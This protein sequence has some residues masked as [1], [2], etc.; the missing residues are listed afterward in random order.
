MCGI[1]GV[2]ANPA[3]TIKS[4]VLEKVVRDV[5]NLSEVRG[6]D[7]SGALAVFPERIELIKSS[8]RVSH[9]VKQPQFAQ[10]LNNA[11]HAYESAN[12]FAVAGHTRMATNGS[13]GKSF[14]NQPVIKDD[15]L[16]LHNGIIVNDAELWELNPALRKEYEVDTEIF[17]ALL[18]KH[19]GKGN[20]FFDA[21]QAAFLKIKGANTIAVL[22]LDR[23]Q[24]MLSTSNGSM[25]FWQARN[26]SVIVFASEK[27]IV[28][29]A[30][31]QF[32]LTRDNSRVQQLKPGRALIIDLTNSKLQKFPLSGKKLNLPER[33][34]K[35]RNLI[36][37]QLQ[38]TFKKDISF[39]SNELKDIE[40]LMQVDRTAISNIKRCTRCLI[41]QT[42]PFIRFDNDG[43]CQLCKQHQP[44]Q[45]KGVSALKTLATQA[46]KSNG[47]PDCLVPISGGRDSCY[48]LHYIKK[49]LDLHPVAYTYDW[50]FVTD[51]ARRN[52]SRMCGE[53]GIEH[54]LVAA[55]IR[56]KREN[57]RKNVTT[58]L[59]NP[60]L[61]MIPLFMAGD[62]MFFYYASMIR[63]QMDLGPILFSMNWL[64]KTGFKTG[65]AHVDDLQNTDASV[66]GKTYGMGLLK[67][68]KL[69]SFY[70]QEFL[71]NPNYLNKSVPDTLQ[72]FFS[73]YVQRKDYD[74]IFDYLP[75]SE[76]II[77]RTIIDGYDWEVSPDTISTW[78]IGDGT[79]P[80]YNYI[81]HKVA[82]FSEHDTFRSNQIREGMITR[83]EALSLI[84]EENQPRVESFKWYC[85]TV[86]I[87]AIEAL[88]IINKMPKLYSC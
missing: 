1:F 47:R 24:M 30:A 51:I 41:P 10:L 42:F 37:I 88:K 26:E 22:P 78:R 61:G 69:I 40:R 29:R 9:L 71:K 84:E 75:W 44:L 31:K 4:Q 25:Y 33:K 50:G 11:C 43:V 45:L 52:I 59:K 13:E 73:Y 38:D 34:T 2:I 3:S 14:N 21:A 57:V 28:E 86:G 12:I 85:D 76:H 5:F 82:G 18:S 7:A 35:K 19:R 62:K 8:Q 80:F 67:K 74:S 27:L 68:V 20:T 60:T 48:G 72:A 87:D 17:G 49:E 83:K 15:Q 23:N 36:N 70:G 79:A 16:I 53:L 46:R 32:K 56:Q 65:F 63:R 64:E 39:F 81:Y 54:V 58:W 6:K 66:E 55:D 77:D